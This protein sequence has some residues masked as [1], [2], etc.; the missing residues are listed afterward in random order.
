MESGIR[1]L[2]FKQFLYSVV[3]PTSLYSTIMNCFRKILADFTHK[4]VVESVMKIRFLFGHYY[5]FDS[6]YFVNCLLRFYSIAFT[7]SVTLLTYMYLIQRITVPLVCLVFEFYF[8][9]FLSFVSDQTCYL[10]FYATMA[11]FSDSSRNFLLL[12]RSCLLLVIVIVL[13]ILSCYFA[14]TFDTLYAGCINIIAL[15]VGLS[16]IPMFMVLDS[17]HLLMKSLRRDLQCYGC[18]INAMNRIANLKKNVNLYNCLLDS[19]YENNRGMQILV[20]CEKH[21][22]CVKYRENR[23]E[24]KSNKIFVADVVN[25]FFK[26]SE[27]SCAN[28]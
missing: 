2:N 26:L 16:Y 25:A 9:I 23:R 17:V 28:V 8:N 15:S 4:S 1:P 3:N 21:F 24:I 12:L 6:S 7:V 19:F 18:G 20:I 5:F 14:W 10:K 11:T 22:F 27:N 13:R